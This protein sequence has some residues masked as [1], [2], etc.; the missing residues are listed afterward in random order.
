MNYIEL[1]NRLTSYLQ[2]RKALGMSVGATSRVLDNFVEFAG[3]QTTA[4]VTSNT[5][6]DWLEATTAQRRRGSNARRL[7]LVRQFL[8][9][10]SAAFPD[11]QVPELRLISGYRRPTPFVFTPHEIELLLKGAADFRPGEFCSV[12]LHTI[13]GLISATGLRASE[14][15]GFDRSDVHASK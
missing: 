4:A 5:V 10:L 15:L 9:H 2:L 13:L 11:T 3:N 7:S 1:Q 12:V 8:L 6:F 14:A